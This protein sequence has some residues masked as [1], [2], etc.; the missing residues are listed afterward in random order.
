[1]ELALNFVSEQALRDAQEHP[2]RHRN[3]MVRL[4]GLSAQFVNLSPQ[5]QERVIERVAAAGR[6][7]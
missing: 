7:G 3:L 2:G 1:M 5:L 4:F 6:R